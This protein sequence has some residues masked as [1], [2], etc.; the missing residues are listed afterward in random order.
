M[1][2]VQHVE[3]LTLLS[4]NFFYGQRVIVLL[5]EVAANL[6][7]MARFMWILGVLAL[8]FVGSHGKGLVEIARIQISVC[9]IV[10]DCERVSLLLVGV[11]KKRLATD[12]PYMYMYIAEGQQCQSY[13][14][15]IH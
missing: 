5:Q 3:N 8:L 11:N 14:I 1:S 15:D 9:T 12:C 10:D 4:P 2:R 7:E 13:Y 6:D